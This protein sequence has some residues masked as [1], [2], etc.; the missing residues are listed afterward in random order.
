MGYGNAYDLGWMGTKSRAPFGGSFGYLQSIL[1]NE[2]CI[3]DYRCEVKA[4]TVESV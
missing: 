4:I 3:L 1:R 2:T